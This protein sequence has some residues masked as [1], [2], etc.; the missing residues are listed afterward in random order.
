MSQLILNRGDSYQRN[1]FAKVMRNFHLGP[2]FLISS[3]V[4]FVALVTVITLMFSTRQVTKG[5]VLEKLESEQQE[6]IKTRE[7]GN[8]RISQ[9]RSLTNIKNS[10][11]VRSMRRPDSLVYVEGQVEIASR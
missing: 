7:E 11:M 9:A 10:S 5:Y 1:L 4:V 8:M 3:L 6:L 2:Y